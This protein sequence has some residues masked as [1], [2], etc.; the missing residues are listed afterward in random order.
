[1]RVRLSLIALV[2]MALCLAASSTPPVRLEVLPANPL[3]FGKGAT[4]RLSVIAH[5]ADGSTRDVSGEARLTSARPAVAEVEAGLVRAVGNGGARI[6]AAFE[7][8]QIETTALVQRADEPVLRSFAGDILPVLTKLG[9][10]GGSCHGA[11]KGQNGFKLSLF[12]YEPDAD[13][14]MIVNEHSGRRINRQDAA[15]SLLLDKPT[16]KVKHGGG[17]LLREDSPEYR[18]LLDWIAAGAAR[19]PGERRMT[20]LRIWPEQNLIFGKDTKQRLLVTARF[21]DGSERDVTALVKFTSND[22]SIA[23]VSPSGIVTAVRGGETAVVVRAPGLTTAAKVGVILDNRPVPELEVFNFVDRHVAAKLKSLHIAPSALAGDTEFL[24][25]ASLDITGVIPSVDEARRFLADPSPDKRARLVDELLTRPEYADYWAVY[26]GDHLSNTRQLLYNKGPYTFSR[27]L[28]QAFRKNLPY[29]QMVRQLLVSSGNMYDAPATSFY[30]VMRK[31][32]D[33]AS[34]TSQ[35]FMGVSIECARCHNHPLEKWTQDDYNGMAA[36][37]TQV[38]YKNGTGPRN[39]ERTLYVDFAR[40]FQHPDTKKP[41]EAKALGGPILTGEGDMVDRRELFTDWLT[42]PNNP[43]FARAIVNR[44][45]RQFMGRGFVEPVDDFRVT[46]P[47][48]NLPLLDEL[49]RDLID[50]KFDL[51]HLI[52]RIAAS[53][54]YQSSSAPVTGNREDTM[55]YSRYYPKRLSAEQLAD[56]ISLAT[57]VWDGY[58]SLYPG[59]RAMQIPDP[60]IE[61]HFLEVFDRP[62][63]QLICERKNTPTLNQ[64][65]HLVSGGALQTKIGS[66]AGVLAKALGAGQPAA[67]IAEDLYLATLSRFPDAGERELARVAVQRAGGARKGLEDL[68]W[69]LVSSKEFLYNH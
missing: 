45:W 41:Y 40:Q 35:I 26:W 17:K 44:M 13:Y 14:E 27:W 18:A 25:R 51:H 61:S 49:A 42:A 64:A 28:Y 66:P 59:T 47:P 48:T 69:A 67:Q 2:P 21:T 9:C 23:A 1:M 29:D 58:K 24:R 37:F 19:Q 56:S 62:S 12:G 30:P 52:R 20:S 3:L 36:V 60:E 43:Y 54:A 6:T 53:R 7:G 5:Y 11:L 55:A 33:M 15:H 63:R 31:E 65:L 10:N 34:M 4:Q 68:F 38:R 16:L 32:L 8:R 57:G 22:D 39:N 50:H 46:N